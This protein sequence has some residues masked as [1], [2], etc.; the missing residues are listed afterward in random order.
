[1]KQ[2]E[3]GE[4]H[5]ELHTQE[6]TEP[7]T[8]G[9]LLLSD[10]TGTEA[11]ALELR[12]PLQACTSLPARWLRCCAP[13]ARAQPRG[14]GPVEASAMFSYNAST[15]CLLL[16]DG[17]NRANASKTGSVE[18]DGEAF[19]LNKT[20]QEGGAQITSG[21]GDR[22]LV[23]CLLMLLQQE[24][25]SPVHFSPAEALAAMRE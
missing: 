9:R 4:W 21:E 8:S 6:R 15:G 1:V 12:R 16:N 11:A 2:N 17:T 7:R 23:E 24:G 19:V 13:H 5:M 14:T 3:A 10:E 22:A 18:T 25:M 20:T